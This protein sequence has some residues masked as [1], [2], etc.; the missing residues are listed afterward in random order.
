MTI[1][2]IAAQLLT[3]F[4]WEE[5][6]IPDHADYPGRNAAVALAMNAALQELFGAGSPW[7]RYDEKGALLRAPA[8]VTITVTHGSSAATITTGWE[9]W[10]AGCAIVID[11]SAFDNQIRNDAAA[12]M[13]KVPHDGPTGSTLATV[14]QD[15]VTLDADVMEVCEP[16]KANRRELGNLVASE[17]PTLPPRDD[18]FGLHRHHQADP[19]PPRV[20]QRIGQ[21]IGYTVDT[22]MKDA[23]SGPR[24]RLKIQ[25]APAVDGVLEYR[26]MLAPPVVVDSLASNAALPIPLQ[27]VQTLFYPIALKRLSSSAFYLPGNS[28]VSVDDDYQS[29]LKLLASLNPRKSAG[30]RFT[31]TY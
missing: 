13:L 19:P 27:F 6:Q 22:W 23:T 18:D 28:E 14:F 9:A 15:C 7:V 4:A 16:V 25:P 17:Y 11:G 2:A 30:A 3:R 21:P 29:A 20:A 26:A 8:R 24:Q 1:N 12:V 10:M 5:R 31:S